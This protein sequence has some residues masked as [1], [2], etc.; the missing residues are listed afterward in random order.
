MDL[1]IY[2]AILWGNRWVILATTAVTVAVVIGS[3]FL[4]TPIYSASTTIRVA[5]ASS[6]SVSYTDYMYTDRLMNT[7]TKLAT[8]RPVLDEL[9]NKLQLPSNPQVKV[10][11]I[12]STELIRISVEDPNPAIAQSAANTLAEILSEQSKELYSGGGK[13]QQQILSEQLVQIEAELKEARQGYES[14]ITQSPDD[15]DLLAAT[16]EAIQLKEKTYATLLDLYEQA[17]L[18]EAIR[19][20]L[21]SV[22]EPATFPTSPIKP[23][24]ALTIGLGLLV[25]LVGGVGLVFLFEN[26]DTRLYTSYQIE[27][28]VEI[29]LIGKIPTIKRKGLLA[30]NR[31]SLKSSNA[32]FKE[33]F[34]RM[35]TKI[36]A[37]NHTYYDRDSIATLAITSSLPDEGKSTIATHLATTMAQAGQKVIVIDCD[38]HLPTQHKINGLSNKIGLSNVLNKQVVV[39]DAIQKSRY[40]DIQ[41]MTSGPIPPNPADLLGSIQMRFVIDQLIQK[42]D[43][44]ILDTP[45]LLAVTDATLVAPMVD[46]VALVARRG[47]IRGDAVREALKHLSDVQARIIGVVVNDAEQNG[48]Y[49]YYHG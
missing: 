23:R 21:V 31:R 4:T 19:A 24:I 16:N 36:L 2:L 10:E 34:R 44:V 37:Q 49:G 40:F 28:A 35:R 42:F 12:P 43:L 25:G 17:R 5:A 14:L 38:L 47:V 13:S 22:V 11:V 26:L 18:K 20:N 1:K 41:V 46:G 9:A 27:E 39:D 6:G 33:A 32:V 15:T 29:P 7:Y 3:L 48:H 8:S 45:A 30:I